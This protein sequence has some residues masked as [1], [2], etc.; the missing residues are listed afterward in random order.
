MYKFF[1]LDHINTYIVIVY[2]IQSNVFFE[3]A[4]FIIDF[5]LKLISLI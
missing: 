5:A 3:T 4:R 2:S 1:S